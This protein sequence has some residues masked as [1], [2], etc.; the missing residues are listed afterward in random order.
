M[1]FAA[2]FRA[3]TAA[4]L[5]IDASTIVINGLSTDGDDIPG[6]ADGGGA[7][8]TS[9]S[10]ITVS[11]EFAASLHATAFDDCYLTPEEMATSPAAM[12]FA[13]AFRESTA[14][15]LGVSPDDIVLDG[16]SRDNCGCARCDSGR[17]CA[18]R[19]LDGRR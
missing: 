19:H 13:A 4:A 12:A 9:G 5:G 10:T 2:A 8:V 1:A 18:E 14:A 6:C 15:S 7:G 3:T 17:D 16:V 11:P